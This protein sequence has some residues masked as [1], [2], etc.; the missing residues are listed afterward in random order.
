M[1][2]SRQFRD[3]AAMRSMPRDLGCNF[4]AENRISILNNSCR[5]LI[6]TAF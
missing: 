5:S 1:F 4:T 2:A 3:Y 6:A